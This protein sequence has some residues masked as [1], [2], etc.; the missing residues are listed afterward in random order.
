MRTLLHGA[1]DAAGRLQ[2]RPE[3]AG[4]WAVRRPRWLVVERVYLLCMWRASQRAHRW[5]ASTRCQAASLDML[6]PQAKACPL[7]P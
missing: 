4:V 1:A 2:G 6:A 5:W 7:K 3:D